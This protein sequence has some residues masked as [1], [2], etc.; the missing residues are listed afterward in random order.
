VRQALYAELTA[1]RRA[2]LHRRIGEAL[3]ELYAHEIER[4]LPELA[5]H[6]GQ[7]SPDAEGRALHYIA[8]AGDQ[9]AAQLA[10]DGAATYYR[11]ALE[12]LESSREP[13]RERHACELTIKLGEAQRRAGHRAYRATLLDG[14]R[15][16]RELGDA[17]LLAR[18]AL[19]NN[20]GFYSSTGQVDDERVAVLREALDAYDPTPSATRARLLSQLGMELSFSGDWAERLSC[21]DEALAMARGIDDASTLAVVLCR[22]FT[23]ILTADTLAERGEIAAEA[24]QLARE[25]DDP[26]VGFYA[27]AFDFIAAHELGEELRCARDLSTMRRI[28]ADVR[29]PIISWYCQVLAAKQQLVNGDLDTAERLA[30]EAFG[31]GR[32]AAQSDSGALYAAQLWLLR[33]QQDRLAELTDAFAATRGLSPIADALLLATLAE[34]G[35]SREALPLLAELLERIEAGLPRDF[36]RLPIVALTALAAA[37]LGPGAPGTARLA[38]ELEPFAAQ[39]VDMGAAWLGSTHLYV[40]YALLGAGERSRALEQLEAAEEAHA[41]IGAVAWQARVQWERAAV[42]EAGPEDEDRLA[43]RRL[44]RGARELMAAVGGELPARRTRAR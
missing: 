42:L 35:R 34:T 3:E 9:A 25:L 2:R 28:A 10:H 43:A 17:E 22:R 1:T 6:F 20:R 31:L 4:H 12:L 5:Y 7:G 30:K 38:Q 27:A 44:R 21:S 15:R 41:R 32:Q 11:Q 13:E 26:L 14:A 18:A 8:R 29:E 40:G 33:W 36:S 23:A 24:E 19:V 16:A 39:Y 37:R